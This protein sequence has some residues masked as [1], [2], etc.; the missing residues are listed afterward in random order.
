MKAFVFHGFWWHWAPNPLIPDPPTSTEEAP[1]PSAAAWMHLSW[2]PPPIYSIARIQPITTAAAARR[3]LRR[4]RRTTTPQLSSTEHNTTQLPLASAVTSRIVYTPHLGSPADRQRVPH[5]HQWHLQRSRSPTFRPLGSDLQVFGRSIWSHLEYFDKRQATS[6]IHLIHLPTSSFV[7]TGPFASAHLWEKP[8][9]WYSKDIQR[10][11]LL[12]S[13]NRKTCSF[14]SG[15][16][17]QTDS[18]TILSTGKLGSPCYRQDQE[19]T[20]RWRFAH[21]A[22]DLAVV[23]DVDVLDLL[24]PRRRLLGRQMEGPWGHV[25]ALIE[26]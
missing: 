19:F 26:S 7:S 25:A 21:A 15:F 12:G 2:R 5:W 9:A 11:S 18:S 22:V 8:W 6:L 10:F 24:R 23:P 3:R 14:P 1:A 17:N 16:L 13:N 4:S 20:L